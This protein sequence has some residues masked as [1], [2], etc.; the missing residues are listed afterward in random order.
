MSDV[1]ARLVAL[2]DTINSQIVPPKPIFKVSRSHNYTD[3]TLDSEIDLSKVENQDTKIVKYFLEHVCTTRDGKTMT[4]QINHTVIRAVRQRISREVMAFIADNLT[5]K[6]P[7]ASKLY[8]WW[9]Q[10]NNDRR[11]HD[12]CFLVWE[13]IS[14]HTDEAHVQNGIAVLNT[15]MQKYEAKGLRLDR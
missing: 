6:H 11:V 14:S 7:K 5:V 9:R 1:N 10:Y 13:Y 4:S 15:M 2:I 8:K 12:N 3:F